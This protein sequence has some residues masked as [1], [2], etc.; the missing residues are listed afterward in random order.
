[1]GYGL[2]NLRFGTRSS[3]LGDPEAC[4]V[5]FYMFMAKSVSVFIFGKQGRVI[6]FVF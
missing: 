5:I 3:V 1:M 6:V 4:E 2:Q